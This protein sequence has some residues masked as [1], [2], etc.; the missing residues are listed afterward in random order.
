MKK[1]LFLISR[2]LDGGIDTVLIEYLRN[3]PAD[4]YDITLAIGMKLDELEVHLPKIPSHIKIVYLV[5]EP[6][7]TVLKKEKIQR[8]LSISEKL[9]DEVLFNPRRR[10]KIFSWLY[11]NAKDYDL[12]VDFDS[13]F[14]SALGKLKDQQPSLPPIVGFYHFSI[15][16]NMKHNKRHTM[17]QFAGMKSYDSIVFICNAMLNEGISLFPNLKSK[18]IRIYNG[19]NLEELRNRVATAK[20]DTFQKPYFLSVARLEESQKDNLTLLRAYARFRELVPDSEIELRLIGK[21]KDE[22]NLKNEAKRLDITDYV[23]FMG[24]RSFAVP[25]IKNAKATILSSKFEGL[26]TVLLE[27]LAM[28]VPTIASDCPTGPSEI[29]DNGKYGV[30]FPIGDAE[31]L[32]QILTKLATDSSYPQSLEE[33][34][35]AGAPRFEISKSIDTLTGLINSDN[36]TDGNIGKRQGGIS[37]VMNTFQAEKYLEEV[38]ESVK[39]ADEIVVVDMHSSDRTREIASR[40]GARII[41]TDRANYC[42]PARN[43]AVKSASNP[44]VLV[45]DADEVVPPAL[46]DFLRKQ[47]TADPRNC[48]T[49]A[50]RIPRRNRFMGRE[51]HALYPDYV[52]R[53]L[54]RDFTEWPKEI[55]SQPVVDGQLNAIPRDRKDLAILHLEENTLES[56]LEKLERYTDFEV[57][58]RGPR[59]YSPIEKLAKPGMRFLRTLLFKGGWRDG[60]A[61]Y[62]WACLEARYKQRTIQKQEEL[63]RKNKP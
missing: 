2:F 35:L 32:A 53:F 58:R 55:H 62:R 29:L 54:A 27:S 26:P 63:A 15:M 6:R 37:V 31:A 34:A 11:G 28:G 16:E 51:M 1:I 13:T 19:F 33:K 5:S 44:W 23:H 49:R 25:Y 14:Y 21:G 38:L 20:T 59:E 3:I 22:E 41:L 17:R 12:I 56:R 18:F 43:L 10:H 39:W 60:S 4:K 24:F 61:G 48:A 52:T 40:Y 8:K 42:E 9:K 57:D 7:L 46:A 50:W 47:A 30:L 36:R 45:L